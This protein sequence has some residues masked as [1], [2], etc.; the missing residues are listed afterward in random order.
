[1]NMCI[2]TICV[3]IYRDIIYN[4]QL[5]YI[6]KWPSNMEQLGCL[7]VWCFCA[8]DFLHR[9]G[10]GIQGTVSR[11]LILFDCESTFLNLSTLES[12]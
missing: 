5:K 9:E 3:Y 6:Q 4:A 10:K 11:Y 1:M 12:V 7:Q 8:R 2:R